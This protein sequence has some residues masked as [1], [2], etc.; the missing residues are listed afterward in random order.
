MKW[1]AKII[2]QVQAQI[3]PQ[4]QVQA[5]VQLQVKTQTASARAS[6]F[7]N[8]SRSHVQPERMYSRSLGKRDLW[9][10]EI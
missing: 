8:L 6:R 5:Q 3:Q 9:L 4:P 7:F 2:V 10:P 1:T